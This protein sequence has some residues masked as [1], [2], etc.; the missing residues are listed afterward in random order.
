MP[1]EYSLCSKREISRQS[2]GL[3]SH[4]QSWYIKAIIWSIEV[5]S[6]IY[7]NEC[8]EKRLVPF[9]HEHHPYSNYIFW[10]DS[11]GC[12]HSKQAVSWVDENFNFVPKEINPPNVPQALPIENFG[13]CLTQ[14]VY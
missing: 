14:K 8:L 6:D 13:G 9:I 1:R 10:P 2:N 4:I 12:H 7:I 3:G 11:D 5:N